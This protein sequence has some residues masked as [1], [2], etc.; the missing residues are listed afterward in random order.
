MFEMNE[1]HLNRNIIS[2]K[3]QVLRIIKLLFEKYF[4]FTISIVFNWFKETVRKKT[5]VN[6]FTRCGAIFLTLQGLF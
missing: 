4:N 3:S 6:F 1:N 5:A 2:W